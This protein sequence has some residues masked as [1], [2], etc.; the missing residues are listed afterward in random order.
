[1]VN[2][3]LIFQIPPLKTRKS[4][5]ISQV[6]ANAARSGFISRVPSAGREFAIAACAKRHSDPGGRH[7]CLSRPTNYSG[8]AAHPR[9]SGHQSSRREG[10]VQNAARRFTCAKTVTRI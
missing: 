6:D 3:W 4:L 7:W 8:H 9:S 1:M 2:K 10:F 5:E